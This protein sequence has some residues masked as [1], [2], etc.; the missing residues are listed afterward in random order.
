M[1]RTLKEILWRAKQGLS[2]AARA[3]IPSSLK[4]VRIVPLATAAGLG[5]PICT[6]FPEPFTYA[7][8]TPE[9]LAVLTK[10]SRYGSGV[11]QFPALRLHEISGATMFTMTGVFADRAGQLVDESDK[12]TA[13]LRDGYPFDQ[14]K[15]SLPP[16]IIEAEYCSTVCHFA[17]SKKYY[18]CLI[19]LV[20][21]LFAAARIP[22]EVT[23]VMPERSVPL[24]RELFEL[25]RPD[26]VRFV[27][28]AAPRVRSEHLVVIPY[29][30]LPGFGYLRA[31]CVAFLRGCI[32]RKI[33]SHGAGFPTRF[34]ISRSRAKQRRV[35]NE[36]QLAPML[37]SFGIEMI[38]AENLS[39]LEQIALFRNAKL[40]V[41]PHGAGL[42]NMLF[43]RRAS[44]VEL[45]PNG[46]SDD[47]N[48]PVYFFGLSESLGHRYR[49]VYHDGTRSGPEFAAD[50]A[51][52]ATAIEAALEEMETSASHA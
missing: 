39:I 12:D 52:T 33:G 28:T 1:N 5:E 43:S 24:A 18:H 37:K 49:A 9:G 10:R 50:P 19:D 20:P 14:P 3:A 31:E 6:V 8:A 22:G 45:Y 7:P 48:L 2:R 36:D 32:D 11:A 41:A 15:L 16:K 40:I 42:S 23:L 26:N 27:F 44:I 35:S 47:G 30:T 29:L 46:L 13:H 17:F 51:R 4:Y 25:F 21:R 34:Y 38:R